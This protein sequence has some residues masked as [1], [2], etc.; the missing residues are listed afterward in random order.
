MSTLFAIRPSLIHGEGLFASEPIT[1]GTLL[2]R[3]EGPVVEQDGPHVLWVWDD[4]DDQF[5]I[6]GKNDLR[7]VN[8]SLEP[9]VEF[10]G[11]ELFALRDIQPG[12]E[13]YHHYGD[14]WVPAA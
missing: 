14:D 5:G 3:Y 4:D 2:G 10:L 9:N 6:D 12:E 8:H 11:A 13:L 1:E 7:F